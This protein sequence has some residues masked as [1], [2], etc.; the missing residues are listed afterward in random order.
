MTVA[1]PDSALKRVG[2]GLAESRRE[3]GLTQSE[4]ARLAGLT[5]KDVSRLENGVP[6]VAWAKLYALV[7]AL[8][9]ATPGVEAGQPPSADAIYRAM[10]A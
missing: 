1:V 7:E 2:A 3:R 4:A 6:G 5:R 9:N 10:H 8:G